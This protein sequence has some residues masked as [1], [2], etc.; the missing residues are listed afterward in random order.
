MPFIKRSG[1]SK[2][3]EVGFHIK[4]GGKATQFIGQLR[5]ILSSA[6]HIKLEI[7]MMHYA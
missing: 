3:M 7:V 6:F 1:W 4:M 2:V 5:R